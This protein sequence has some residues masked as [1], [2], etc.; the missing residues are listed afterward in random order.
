MGLGGDCGGSTIATSRSFRSDINYTV[1]GCVLTLAGGALW[2]IGYFITGSLPLLDWPS[3]SP[4]WIAAYLPNWQAEAGMV[5]ATLGQVAVMYGHSKAERQTLERLR[6]DAEAQLEMMQQIEH[7][8]AV[9]T[10]GQRK[11]S[12]TA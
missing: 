12:T 10:S 2:I 11:L 5:L 1:I 7:V 6:R 3:F 9:H 8:E 4:Q